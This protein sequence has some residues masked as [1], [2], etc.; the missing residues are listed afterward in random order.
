MAARYIPCTALVHIF[1]ERV[2][3]AFCADESAPVA[4]HIRARAQHKLRYS[5]IHKL[6]RIIRAGAF[7]STRAY[8]KQ[9]IGTSQP[10]LRRRRTAFRPMT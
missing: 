9:H 7:A 3:T 2:A 6:N 1:V 4:F 8:V 5:R 10:N